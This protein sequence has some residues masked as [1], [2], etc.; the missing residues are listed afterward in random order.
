MIK[1]DK[2]ALHFSVDHDPY[3]FAIKVFCNRWKPFIIH[4]IQ[5]D[6]CTRYSAFLHH[7][8]ITEKV[9]ANNL[10]ELERDG[11][12]SRNVYPEVPPRVEY[13]LT[14]LG[15]TVCP[16]LDSIYRWGREEMIRRNMEIDMIGEMW[17][18]YCPMDTNIL[19]NSL[20]K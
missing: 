6:T 17:H 1:S 9:L 3:N 8:P 11:L 14:E 12:I 20:L 2:R 16:I 13:S 18:G 10:R 4:A 5:V 15:K 7:L 19:K